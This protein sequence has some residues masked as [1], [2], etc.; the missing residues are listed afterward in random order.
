MTSVVIENEILVKTELD[1]DATLVYYG[2]GNE[3]LKTWFIT[4]TK[5]AILPKG[6]RLLF[7]IKGQSTNAEIFTSETYPTADD[8]IS[9]FD[10]KHIKVN[11]V[12]W[13]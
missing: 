13:V 11:E 1:S 4:K 6:S 3:Q 9:T 2:W 10:G 5:K 12:N 8:V 7:K